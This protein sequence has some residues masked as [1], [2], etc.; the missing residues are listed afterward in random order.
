ML[1]R[2]RPDGAGRMDIINA[3]S[4]QRL[5]DAANEDEAQALAARREWRVVGMGRKVV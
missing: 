2:L 1:V 4:E 5:G 3:T